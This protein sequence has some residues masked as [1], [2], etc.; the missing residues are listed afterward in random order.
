VRAYDP[1]AEDRASQML[2]GVQ[3]CDTALDC[4]KGADAVVIVT[5]WAEFGEL[6]LAEMKKRMAKPIVVDGRNMLNARAVQAAG[7]IYEGIGRA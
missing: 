7:L 3:M 6:D 2:T 5:E 4:I 1:V